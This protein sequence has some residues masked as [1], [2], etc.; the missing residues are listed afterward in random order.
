MAPNRILPI[1]DRSLSEMVEDAESVF[2]DMPENGLLAE[3]ES[4]PSIIE[5]IQRMANE[6]DW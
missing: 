1:R 5:E 6:A 3:I 4:E 2:G